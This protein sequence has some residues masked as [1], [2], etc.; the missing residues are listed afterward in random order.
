MRL[1]KNKKRGDNKC[2]PREIKRVMDVYIL[3]K[4]DLVMKNK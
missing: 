4:I 1:E 2:E 3:D